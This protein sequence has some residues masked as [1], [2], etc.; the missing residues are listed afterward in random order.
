VLLLCLTE[1]PL[2]SCWLLMANLQMATTGQEVA[3]GR[4]AEGA[5]GG[6]LEAPN[7][8]EDVVLH[9]E[10]S[11]GERLDGWPFAV[12]ACDLPRLVNLTRLLAG[13]LAYL[14]AAQLPYLL[15]AST[16]R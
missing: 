4:R 13:W 6:P 2:S 8:V 7:E 14:P 11:V 3:L 1:T 5:G 9:T 10:R 16:F 12:G 15:C